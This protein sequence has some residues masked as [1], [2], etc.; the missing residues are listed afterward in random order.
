MTYEERVEIMVRQAKQGKGHSL[1]NLIYAG[2]N[3]HFLMVKNYNSI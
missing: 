2:E 1:Y 3:Y